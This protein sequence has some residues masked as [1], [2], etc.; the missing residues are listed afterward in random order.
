MDRGIAILGR[1]QGF[2]RRLSHQHSKGQRIERARRHDQLIRVLDKVLDAAEA[3][4]VKGV[5]S[6][7]IEG[8]RNVGD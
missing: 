2:S 7:E 5:R 4:L 1:G 6:G 8:Q 3:S